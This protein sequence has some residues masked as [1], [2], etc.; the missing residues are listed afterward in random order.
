MHPQ[1][2]PLPHIRAG[3]GRSKVGGEQT[4]SATSL[5]KAGVQ[6]VGFP[7]EKV[8]AADVADLNRRNIDGPT[9]TDDLQGVAALD[10]DGTLIG[11]ITLGTALVTPEASPGERILLCLVRYLAVEEP[12][13][14]RGIATVLL[15]IMDQN[16]IPENVTRS[17]FYG[18][19]KPEAAR[20]YQRTGFDVLQPDTRLPG[21]VMGTGD[22]DIVNENTDYPCW[23]IRTWSTQRA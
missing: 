8:S 4:R 15:C 21:S 18:G 2:D 14:H 6:F 12:W 19:C 9:Q 10:R 17:V 11:A 5:V 7:S 22:S 3:W 20:L 16:G 13:R 1:I 23:F